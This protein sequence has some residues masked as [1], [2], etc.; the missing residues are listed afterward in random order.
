MLILYIN[1][2]SDHL[3]NAFFCFLSLGSKQLWQ[4]H[5]KNRDCLSLQ[6]VVQL[7]PQVSFDNDNLPGPATWQTLA[8]S[9]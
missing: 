4:K 7:W 3:S 6:N 2:Y 8:S 1:N 9:T 5:D